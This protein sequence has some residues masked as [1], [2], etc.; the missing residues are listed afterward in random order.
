MCREANWRHSR[1]AR[2]QDAVDG[3]LDYRAPDGATPNSLTAEKDFRVRFT[4]GD[5]ITTNH[6][7]KTHAAQRQPAEHAADPRMIAG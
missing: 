5:L 3:V 6:H 1:R 4:V 2:R 7:R